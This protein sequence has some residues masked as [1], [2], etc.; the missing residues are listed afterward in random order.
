M[1]ME[2][3]LIVFGENQVVGATNWWRYELLSKVWLQS[4]F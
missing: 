2:V 3:A 4:T 1:Y